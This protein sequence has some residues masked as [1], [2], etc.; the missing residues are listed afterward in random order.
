MVSQ[1]KK[2]GKFMKHPKY[3]LYLFTEDVL[4]L[5]NHYTYKHKIIFIAGLPKSGTTW[6]ENFFFNVPGYRP[7]DLTGDNNVYLK[8]N[9]PENAF[10]KFPKEGYS[11]VKTHIKATKENLKILKKTGINKI[12][13]M[14]R[15]PRDIVISRYY[16]ILNKPK[17]PGEPH[18]VSYKEMKIDDGLFHSM[19][20]V[21]SDFIPWIEGWLAIAKSDPKNYLIIRYEDLL[22]DPINHFK[23]MLEFY[24]IEFDQK[25][26]DDILT[27]TQNMKNKKFLAP[28]MVGES[29]TFRKGIA[30]DWK[31][32][33][34]DEHKKMFKEKAGDF[35]IELGYEKDLNW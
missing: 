16:H 13:I 5:L 12:I 19:N 2:F 17:K 27:K 7:R 11:F 23:K 34:N 22:T 26:L 20:V 18:N 25:Q 3:H 33:F 4:S 29:S 21:F 10:E 14:F 9:L 28:Y 30:G 35:L 32:H 6:V 31:N 8:L 15:D 1:L 24:S